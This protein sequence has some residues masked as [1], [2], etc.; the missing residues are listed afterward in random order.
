MIL[1]VESSLFYVLMHSIPLLVY[2][3]I[4]I[5]QNIFYAYVMCENLY[6]LMKLSW[7]KLKLR[8]N[9]S[10]KLCINNL[11]VLYTLQCKFLIMYFQIMNYRYKYEALRGIIICFLYM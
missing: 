2:H 8:S 6:I 11:I 5:D 9:F 7:C 1:D 10:R 3:V 4:W